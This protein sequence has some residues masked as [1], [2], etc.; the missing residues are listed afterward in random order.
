MKTPISQ[1][2]TDNLHKAIYATDAS[3]YRKLPFAVAYPQNIEEIK[4]LIQYADANKLSIT[5]RAGG[6]SLGGQ[7]VTEGIVMDISRYFTEILHF[8]KETKTVV[9]QPGVIRDQ[10]NDFLKPHGLFFGPNTSTTNRCTIGGMVGNNSSGTT[11]IQYGVTRDK[12]VEIKALLS[13]GSEVVFKDLSKS[14]I[15]KKANQNDLEG[16]IYQL[17][18]EKLSDKE[19]QNEIRKEFPKQTIHRRNNGYAVD[20][21]LETNLFSDKE[22]PFNLSKLIAGSEGTIAIITEITLK[23]DDLPPPQSIVVAAHFNDLSEA[24]KAVVVSMKHNLYMCELMDKTILDQTK[25][26]RTQ[27][28]NRDFIEGDPKAILMLEVAAESLEKADQLADILIADLQKNKM[29]YAFPK[30]SGKN[31]KKAS[32]LRAAGLGLLGNIIGDN[33]SVACIE[34]TAVALEDLINRTL[35]IMHMPAPENYICDRFLI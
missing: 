1:Y 11:S 20:A 9:I 5:P 7:C 31:V 14:E 10:L 4:D 16:K 19:I 24:M 32:D 30:L 15:E 22:Q 21:L 8:D 27:A 6:T 33:K 3:V 23:L 35:F 25:T 13:D 18:F 2:Y 28:K 26:N 29:G 12:L 34:D 17:L